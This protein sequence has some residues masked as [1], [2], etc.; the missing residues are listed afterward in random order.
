M[1]LHHIATGI[2]TTII[3]ASAAN[4][5]IVCT[6]VADA[7]TGK[8]LVQQ[9]ACDERVTPASTFKIAISLMGYDSGFLKDAHTPQLPYR[10]GYV[11]WGGASWR[12]P[13]DPARWIKYSVVWFSQQVTQLL[14]KERFASYTKRFQFGNADV[15]GDAKHDGLTHAWIDSSLK[16]SPMEQV[17]FLEK[18][19]NRQLPVSQRAY[20]VTDEITEIRQLP[21]GWAIHGKT[22]TGFPQMADGSDDQAH[23][24]GWFVGWASKGQRTIVFARLVQDDRLEPRAAPT[25]IQARDSFVTELPALATRIAQ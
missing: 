21:G 1:Y 25:G 19:V 24:W 22:G 23:G 11:D 17:S 8:M 4:A 5:H 14:G 18:V 20:D 6:A 15:S 16:I 3:T 13:T 2:F 7:R 12:Q 9:G 10:E